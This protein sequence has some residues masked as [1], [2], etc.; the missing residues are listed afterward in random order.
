MKIKRHLNSNHFTIPKF[1]FAALFAM[2]ILTG[3]NEEDKITSLW[4]GDYTTPL[5]APV[6]T[7]LAPANQGLAGVTK[8]TID[9]ENFSAIKENN[10]VF[11]NGSRAS[12]L[13]A[14]TTRLVIRAPQI[15]SDSLIIKIAVQGSLYFSEGHFYKLKPSIQEYYG[16]DT[17]L[18]EKPWGITLDATGNLYVSLDGKNISK[19]N[20][21]RLMTIWAP[22]GIE[23]KWNSL[24]FG[25]SNSI[26]AA[27][28]LR[29]V[30]KI[31]EG[32]VPTNA[33][34][35]ISPSGS[36]ISDM[37]FDNNLNLWAVGTNSNLTNNS[38]VVM[39]PDLTFKTY[40]FPHKL[41][42]VRYFSSHL[43][44]AGQIEGKEAVW[45]ALVI[46][47]S[48][49]TP[50]LYFNYS[51]NV[52]STSTINALT[53]AE[54][55][56]LYIATNKTEDPISIVHPDGSFEPLY[57]GNFEPNTNIISMCWGNDEF[58]YIT[59]AEYTVGGDTKLK[60]TILAVNME[61]QG[62]IYHGRN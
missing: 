18:G 25:P 57:P 13:E 6:I 37:D 11:F 52:H 61:K 16:F 51:D 33:P 39:K 10:L 47:D 20:T 21:D 24:Q 58:L 7:S 53:F 60:Q 35:V 17:Q 8:I 44:F 62:A 31:T 43:Y 42:A 19:I 9:G 40:S 54:D 27:K 15:V 41:S 45:R 32:N 48:I 30:W 34:W 12:V 4:N 26:Y 23:T 3:C 46:G 49:G 36:S 14:S 5:P 50:E 38:I 1:I 56:D 59:R 55:G 28:I 29:G 22:K 2:I